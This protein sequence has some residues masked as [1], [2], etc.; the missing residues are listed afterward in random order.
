MKIIR[1]ILLAVITPVICQAQF[2]PMVYD[3]NGDEVGVLIFQSDMWAN[4]IG[5]LRSD[6]I[7]MYVSQRYG[8]GLAYLFFYPYFQS[9]DCT[10]PAFIE[11]NHYWHTPTMIRI[12]SNSPPGDVALLPRVPSRKDV[13]I[14]SAT[15]PSG[16]SNYSTPEVRNVIPL[17]D[18]IV[19]DPSNYGLVIS[20]TSNE[21]ALPSPITIEAVK[22]D[23]ISCNGF[24]SCPTP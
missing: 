14:N 23:V 11:V 6:G 4:D 18:Y 19:D 8:D 10:G 15:S 2:T 3:A 22:P 20:P 1:T 17:S 5:I 12:P 24:E 16:C 7:T 21:W 9:D 13:E